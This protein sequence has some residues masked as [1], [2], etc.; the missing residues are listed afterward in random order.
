LNVYK[1][2]ELFQLELLLFFSLSFYYLLFKTYT[3]K[4]NLF[5]IYFQHSLSNS[6]RKRER[7]EKKS[8]VFEGEKNKFSKKSIKKIEFKLNKRSCRNQKRK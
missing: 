7:E 8:S 6:R 2:S 5:A 1:I 3:I 4:L